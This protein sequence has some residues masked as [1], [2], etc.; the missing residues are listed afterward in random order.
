MAENAVLVDKLPPVAKA[1][2]T[3]PAPDPKPVV[4]ERAP[5]VVAPAPAS[6]PVV[7]P[8]APDILS[9]APK[10]K[11]TS[12]Y[13]PPSRDEPEDEIVVD[14]VLGVKSVLEADNTEV[15]ATTE[16]VA[17]E[18]ITIT[19]FEEATYHSFWVD[20][21]I[22]ALMGTFF[23]AQAYRR[24]AT[25][26]FGSMIGFGAFL[27]VLAASFFV[28]KGR[29][30]DFLWQ[31]SDTNSLLA[32]GFIWAV[33]APTLFIMLS[34]LI[35]VSK[36]DRPIYV[37]MFIVAS[38]VFIF[39]ALSNI[40]GISQPAALILA[41]GSF[42]C[43]AILIVMLFFTL[44]SLPEGVP[45]NLHRG[46]TVI[47]LVIASG[48]FLYPFLNLLAKFLESTAVY[49]FLYNVVD[50]I[51][52]SL[53]AYGFYQG[54]GKKADRIVMKPAFRKAKVAPSTMQVQEMQEEEEAENEVTSATY[55]D[56][57][58]K[59]TF[60]RPAKKMKDDE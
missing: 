47:V 39:I 2:S 53:I 41:L 18:D 26:H 29:Y 55:G 52:V 50:V 25:V 5:A 35:H 11:P 37:V 46:V 6:R 16:Q 23:V 33:L 42:A 31:E 34:R 58:A 51:T 43:S 54:A 40:S 48:W 38:S 21:V 28:S 32:R 4:V 60:R 19:G 17:K 45:E 57:P 3:I 15:T 22:F 30:A 49:P 44:G 9:A 8:K 1:Q 14:S 7:V 10:Q 59:P 24:R 27:F 56:A 13:V 36:K 20:M 12:V